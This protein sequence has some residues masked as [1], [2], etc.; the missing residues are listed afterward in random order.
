MLN[1]RLQMLSLSTLL[2]CQQVYAQV[3]ERDLGDFDLKL[4]TT[5]TRSMAQGLVTPNGNS[6]SFHGGL[7]L[8]HESGFYFGQWSPNMGFTEDTT[9]EVD[10]Y[11]GF[12]KPFDNT[13]GY[14]L[15]MIRYSYPDTSQIDSH[16]FY[17]GLRVLNSRVGAAFSNDVGIRNSTVF[18]DLGA[19]EQLGLGV[20]MQYANHQFDTPQAGDDGSLISGFNDWS[21]KLS[22]PW[23]G[24]DMN[25]IY[26]GSSLSGSDCSV[27]SGHNSRCEGMFT[28]KAVRSFF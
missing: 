25:L 1:L 19:I 7:D 27:Y 10:S 21:L 6:G 9:L 20:R 26:S 11:M 18:I 28:I 4:A 16:E 14:E 5:P 15:G 24:I 3:L 23:L 13:L 2:L 8:T 12:K 17:A 22:R